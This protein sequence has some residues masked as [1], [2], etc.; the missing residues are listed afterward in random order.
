MML[1]KAKLQQAKLQ[2]LSSSINDCS[3][4]T[5]KLYKLVNSIPGTS[6]NNPLPDK[7]K[8][9]DEFADY[10]LGKIQKI[11]DQPDHYDKYSPLNKDIPRMSSF[12]PVS[13]EEV[14]KLVKAMP[15]SYET[16]AISAE[17]LKNTLKHN[18]IDK[19]HHQPVA[20]TGSICQKLENSHCK[21]IA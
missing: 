7:E 5:K 8:L 3:N 6:K 4:D 17:L 10:F 20:R 19:K 12:K 15:K 21:T 11:R 14:S 9:A 13:K 2:T 16:N 1:Y 18:R